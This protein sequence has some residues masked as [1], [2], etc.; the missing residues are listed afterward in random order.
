MENYFIEEGKLDKFEFHKN[1]S[2]GLNPWFNGVH[3][4]TLRVTTNSDK[5]SGTM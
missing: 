5:F 1:K 2:A 3:N 4:A